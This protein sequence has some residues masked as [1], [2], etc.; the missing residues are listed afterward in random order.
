MLTAQRGCRQVSF[1]RLSRFKAMAESERDA[2]AELG[3]G[4]LRGGGAISAKA[5]WM[6]RSSPGEREGRRSVPGRG[7]EIMLQEQKGI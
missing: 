6:S 2:S 3:L 1:S 7:T 4:A 5:W